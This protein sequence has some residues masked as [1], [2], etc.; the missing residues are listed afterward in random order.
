MKH[1]LIGYA[2][3]A[4]VTIGA[5]FFAAA[6]LTDE[7]PN[8]FTRNLA[9]TVSDPA[10]PISWAGDAPEHNPIPMGQT[11]LELLPDVWVRGSF[12]IGYDPQS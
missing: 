4:L 7:A 3:I 5:A 1:T 11:R 8:P 6:A 12:T 10:F 9:T 2:L